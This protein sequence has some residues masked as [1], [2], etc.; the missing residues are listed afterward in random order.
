MNLRG[1][2]RLIADAGLSLER[3]GLPGQFRRRAPAPNEQFSRG[4]DGSV[5][6]ELRRHYFHSRRIDSVVIGAGN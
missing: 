1:V 4:P 6:H 3:L 5:S 2:S